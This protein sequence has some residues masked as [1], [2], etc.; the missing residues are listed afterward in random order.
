MP[1]RQALEGLGERFNALEEGSRSMVAQVC[2]TSRKEMR[3]SLEILRQG[4]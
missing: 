2:L 3:H 4:K 1:I